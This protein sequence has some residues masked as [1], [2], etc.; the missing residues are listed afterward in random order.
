MMQTDCQ[1]GESILP[2]LAH[3]YTVTQSQ[4]VHSKPKC[5]FYMGTQREHH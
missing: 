3:G 1:K 4:G 5:K 2:S